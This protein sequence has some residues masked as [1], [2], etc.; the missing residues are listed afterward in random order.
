MQAMPGLL[1]VCRL[2]DVMALWR[3]HT[4][5]QA[6]LNCPVRRAFP[7]IVPAMHHHA[8]R[9]AFAQRRYAPTL[10]AMPQF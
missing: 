1:P 5:A 7:H 10:S 4:W 2:S 8:R 6:C 3:V 9:R